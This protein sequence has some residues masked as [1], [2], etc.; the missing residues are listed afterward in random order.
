MK[1]II[2]DDIGFF[3]SNYPPMD[4]DDIDDDR[5]IWLIE[6]YGSN[7]YTD[8]GISIGDEKASVIEKYGQPNFIIGHLWKLN[9]QG[10]ISQSFYKLS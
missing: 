9:F 8:R 3:I 5:S 4:N 6:V 10:N 1:E 2:S 7:I